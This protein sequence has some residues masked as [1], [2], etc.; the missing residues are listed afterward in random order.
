MAR[1][2]DIEAKLAAYVD[3]ELD[4][5]ARAEIEKHLA[6]N[7]QHRTLIAELMQQR[8]LLRDLPRQTAPADVA[9]TINA[10]LERAVLLGDVDDDADTITMRIS[11]WGQIRAIAAVIVLTGGLAAAIWLLLPSPKHRPEI[12]DI[13]TLPTTRDF[14]DAVADSTA[15]RTEAA[16]TTAPA[17]VSPAAAPVMM[18]KGGALALSEQER[19]ARDALASGPDLS[20]TV[21]PNAMSNTLTAGERLFQ[22]VVTDQIGAVQ[23]KGAAEVEP[24]LVVISTPDLLA[25]NRAVTDY[26]DSNGIRWEAHAQPMPAP[27]ELTAQQRV[28]ASRHQQ[29]RVQMKGAYGGGADISLDRGRRADQQAATGQAASKQLATSG[30]VQE[31]VSQQPMSQQIAPQQVQDF[32]LAPQAADERLKLSAGSGQYIV[33][34]QIPRRQAIEIYNTLN[35]GRIEAVSMEAKREGGSALLR[36]TGQPI[37][38]G[39]GFN[40]FDPLGEMRGSMLGR[41]V[42][43]APTEQLDHRADKPQVRQT[44]EAPATAPAAERRIT[45][46]DTLTID[47]PE[48]VGAAGAETRR[49]FNVVEGATLSLPL[50]EPIAVEGMTAAQLADTIKQKYEVSKLGMPVN[51]HVA[52]SEPEGDQASRQV[53]QQPYVGGA[54]QIVLTPA[55][56]PSDVVDIV[57]LVASEDLATTQPATQSADN[58]APNP[59]ATQPAPGQVPSQP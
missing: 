56:Q 29:T 27:L 25:T 36:A 21:A 3:D 34:R 58:P 40:F 33:A 51:P 1:T 41:P 12:A 11:P 2:E 28:V 13:R 38:P 59:L 18:G 26:L 54:Q 43:S 53:P 4:P 45:V 24:L 35:S 55:S 20:A 49:A 23:R 46:G 44:E 31:Q 8:Q 14:D 32:A 52:L 16:P 22:E 48:L 6:G 57:I 9:E 5:A 15:V 42:E 50:I 10:Q 47:V 39:A 7:P 19:R 17:T 30:M 37:I